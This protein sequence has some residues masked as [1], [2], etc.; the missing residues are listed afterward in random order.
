[1]NDKLLTLL[2]FAAKSGNLSY[3]MNSTVSSVRSNRAKLVLVCGDISEKS[4]KEITF[5][6]KN[7][8]VKVLILD[9]YNIQVVC[10]AVGKNCG[11]LSINDSLFADAVLRVREQGGNV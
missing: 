2:G 4:K 8:D 3:G 1:M 7:S 10:D 6:C 11:I 9:D 5:Y